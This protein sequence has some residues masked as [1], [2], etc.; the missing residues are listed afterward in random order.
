MAVGACLL[1]APV[2]ATVHHV[3]GDFATIGAAIAAAA[4]G[5]TIRVAAGTYAPSTNGET[6]PL[7][8][9]DDDVA[10]LGAGMGLCVLDAEGTA[11]VLA[12]NAASGGRVHGFT[13]RGGSAPGGGGLRIG[14]GSPEVDGNLFLQNGAS[15]RGAAIFALRDSLP[16]SSAWIHHNVIWDNFDTTPED[17]VDTHGVVLSGEVGGVFEHNL[18]GL[19]DG[20]GL[21]TNLAASTSVR[22]NLFVENGIPGPPPRGRGI[23]WLGTAPATILHNLFWA[24]EIAAVLWPP[25]GG[26]FSGAAANDVSPTDDVYGNLD[27]DPLH[28]DP[29][30]LDFTLTVGSPAIDAGDPA[31]PLDPDGTVADLGPFWFDQGGI[32]AAPDVAAGRDL[33]ALHA[34]PNPFRAATRVAFDLAREEPVEVAIVDVAGRV[35]RRLLRGV[36]S[37]GSHDVSWDGRDEAGRPVA[38][39]VYLAVVRA[40][41]RTR[42][43]PLVRLR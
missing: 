32:V 18:V 11:G 27:G 24:N 10:L 33:L 8:I 29:D 38:A 6:F 23:C 36:R 12:W 17:A 20:N 26:N 19:T 42:S 39:G 3:P 28:A 4:P 2:G 15:V 43:A 21:L 41:D 25:A 14:L 30:A 40:G 16:T 34:A 35:V 31:L 37:A 7:A 1:A 5:D 9:T 13:I 22:H